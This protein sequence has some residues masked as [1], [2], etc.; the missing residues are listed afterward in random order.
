MTDEFGTSHERAV[1]V[2]LVD[3]TVPAPVYSTQAP[4]PSGNTCR[5]GVSMKAAQHIPQAA[6]L[7]AARSC[8]RKGS[9]HS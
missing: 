6:A 3:G 7:R 5:G 2:L 4:G 9:E 1:E 8:D